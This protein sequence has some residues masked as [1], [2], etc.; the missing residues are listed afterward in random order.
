MCYCDSEERTL[1]DILNDLDRDPYEPLTREQRRERAAVLVA[2]INAWAEAPIPEPKPMTESQRRYR[3]RVKVVNQM[4]LK[5][6]KDQL[7]NTPRI[8][9]IK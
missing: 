8:Y 4:F 3:E 1:A 5:V 6:F 2:E 9:N 7:E